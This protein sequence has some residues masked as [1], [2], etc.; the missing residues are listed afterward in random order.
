MIS[1][2]PSLVS[3]S[4]FEMKLADMREWVAGWLVECATRAEGRHFVG[5]MEDRATAK[6]H[7]ITTEWLDECRMCER[8]VVD[9]RGAAG[10]QREA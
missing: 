8:R 4:D 2:D 7:F 9:G 1:L 3:S 10:H 6:M 5:E